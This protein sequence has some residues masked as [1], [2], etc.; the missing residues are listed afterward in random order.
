[1]INFHPLVSTMTRKILGDAV[2]EDEHPGANAVAETVDVRPI[3]VAASVKLLL[4]WV[5]GH[6]DSC[7]ELC[8]NTFLQY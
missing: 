4:N 5:T 2:A 3:G 8:G 1:M 7:S 6:G